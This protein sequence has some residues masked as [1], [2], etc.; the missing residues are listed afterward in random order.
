MRI[1]GITDLYPVTENEIHTPR[2]IEA[3]VKSWENLGHEVRVI[4]PNF[5]LNSFLRKKPYYRN[6]IYGQIE[7]INY[8]LP[9]I[10]DIKK[11][12]K[13]LFAPDI[14]IAN[15]KNAKKVKEAGCEVVVAGTFIFKAENYQSQIDKIR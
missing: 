9:F 10:G 3:F 14:V 8:I 7:N 15:S 12:I 11:K 4:K 1:L 2:T 6:G 13:T 5:L